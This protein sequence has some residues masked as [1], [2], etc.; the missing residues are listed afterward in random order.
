MPFLKDRQATYSNYPEITHWSGH[1]ESW[2]NQTLL[3]IKIIRYE[4]MIHDAFTVFKEALSFLQLDYAEDAIRRALQFSDLKELQKQESEKGS[5]K[6]HL[7]QSVFSKRK[8]GIME[9]RND[10]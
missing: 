3:P 5:E 8:N 6:K 7:N 9:R 4:D 10:L 1:V 2:S